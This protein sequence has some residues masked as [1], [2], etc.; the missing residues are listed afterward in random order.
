MFQTFRFHHNRTF[1]NFSFNIR[2]PS[3]YSTNKRISD[4]NH[5]K[6]L[7]YSGTRSIYD[8]WQVSIEDQLL[9]AVEYFYRF[10]KQ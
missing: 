5:T 10:L 3:Y 2:Y 4:I 6:L 7:L 9:Q 8:T 1:N